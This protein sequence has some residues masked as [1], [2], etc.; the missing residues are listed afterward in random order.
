MFNEYITDPSLQDIIFGRE[1]AECCATISLFD[2]NPHNSFIFAHIN[3]G[4]PSIILFLLIFI[5]ILKTKEYELIFFIIVLYIRY[6]LDVM[7]LSYF[8]T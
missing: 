6:S 5:T 3:Y 7:V 4:I 8:Q 2:N 1:I